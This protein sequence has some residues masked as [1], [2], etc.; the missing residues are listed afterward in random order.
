MK[1]LVFTLTLLFA[2]NIESQC[3]D[4]RSFCMSG[5]RDGWMFNN[6]SKSATF[7]KGE[8][9]EMSFIAYKGISYRL[10]VCTDLRDESEDIEFEIYESK[11]VKREENGRLR[12][13]KEY[14]TIYSN[15]EDEMSQDFT[16]S[17]DKTRKLYLR[18]SVPNGESK[19]KDNNTLDL[20]CVGVLLEHQKTP[21]TGF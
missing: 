6:Q 16:F 19:G 14:V 12:Y 7:E 10:A 2:G 17:S 15:K 11:S 20:L 4:S 21:K 5:S 1:Y 3:P 13:S 18:M 9:Y 8:K